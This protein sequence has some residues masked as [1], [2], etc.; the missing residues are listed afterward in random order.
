MLQ[1]QLAQAPAALGTRRHGSRRLSPGDTAQEKAED[2]ALPHTRHH[3]GSRD[4]GDR[5]SILLT[6]ESL[7]EG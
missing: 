1:A 5:W 2:I 7:W 6:L 3:L 4:P